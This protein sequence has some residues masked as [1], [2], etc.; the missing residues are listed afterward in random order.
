[1]SKSEAMVPTKTVQQ[2]GTVHERVRH[3]HDAF[4][5]LTVVRTQGAP[6]ALFGSAIEHSQAVVIEIERAHLDRHL[7]RDWIHGDETMLRFAV[8]ETAWAQIVASV[9]SGTGTP[10]TLEYAP[11]RGTRI[12]AMPGLLN[13]P[14]RHTF[15]DEVRRSAAKA[16]EGILRARDRVAEMTKPGAKPPSKA[17]LAALLDLLRDGGDHFESNMGHV[18]KQFVATMERTVASA[19]TEI[20]AT[21][22]ATAMRLGM[23]QLRERAPR[24]PGTGTEGPDAIEGT[25]EEVGG[26]AGPQG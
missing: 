19:Q 23:D 1:M 2:E 21:V 26:G 24:L 13:E 4:A 6:Q 22:A 9:G 12:A 20:E 11:P 16:A 7:N 8:S 10:I 3:D 17:D 5:R 14:V 25:A 15:E 18:Q